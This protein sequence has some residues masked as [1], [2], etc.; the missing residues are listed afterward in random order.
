[1][2][3]ENINPWIEGNSSSEV[4]GGPR[5]VVQTAFNLGNWMSAYQAAQQQNARANPNSVRI[6][7]QVPKKEEVVEEKYE[8]G[9]K[10]EGKER[11]VTPLVCP[12]CQ[13]NRK[14][15]RLMEPDENLWCESCL[16]GE[17]LGHEPDKS[18][19]PPEPKGTAPNL[20]QTFFG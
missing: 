11:P 12:R 7:A 4:T 13:W 6:E 9:W 8:G 2:T 18:Y 10:S 3:E 16:N 14:N 17:V 15:A 20:S 5:P 19:R 1:M